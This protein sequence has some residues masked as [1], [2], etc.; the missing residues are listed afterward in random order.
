MKISR[1]LSAVAIVLSVGVGEAIAQEESS[2][3]VPLFI[4]ATVGYNNYLSVEA[5]NGNNTYYPGAVAPSPTW[6]DKK[7]MV[8][9][10]GGAYLNND[11]RVLIGGG[12]SRTINNGNPE[13]TGV[14]D[15]PSYDQSPSKTSVNFTGL[16]GG[17]YILNQIFQGKAKPYVGIRA[18]GAYGHNTL[19][20]DNSASRGKS[21]AVT[22]NIG[23]AVAIGADYVF[24]GGL[25]IGAQFDL[26][27]YNYGLVSYKPQP[28]LATNSDDCHNIGFLAAPTL[29]IGFRF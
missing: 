7:L 24:D 14:G 11:I 13:Y 21:I 15:I 10:E 2:Q 19:K 23:G 4:S 27:S 1:Y 9:F 25:I 17:D 20:Y 29:R 3:R 6:S 26:F 8:G 28:G 5:P 22:W 12:Y 18:R 16:V